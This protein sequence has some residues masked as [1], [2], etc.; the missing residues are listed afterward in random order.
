MGGLWK[1]LEMLTG[2]AALEYCKLSLIGDPGQSSEDQI[3]DR[4]ASDKAQTQKI[5]AENRFIWQLD[6]M[7]VMPC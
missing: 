5:S 6:S 2:E 3:N 4:H 7:C 1:G